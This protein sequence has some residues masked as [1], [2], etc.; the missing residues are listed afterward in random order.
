MLLTFHCAKAKDMEPGGTYD[1]YCDF[2]AKY[3]QEEY[4]GYIYNPSL[5]LFIF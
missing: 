4:S 2:M 5:P 3:S 1:E